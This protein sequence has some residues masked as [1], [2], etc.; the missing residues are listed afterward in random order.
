MR[1][2]HNSLYCSF[3]CAL[4]P[5][6]TLGGGGWGGGTKS[7]IAVTVCSVDID[8]RGCFSQVESGVIRSTSPEH[9]DSVFEDGVR[10]R[11]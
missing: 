1:L 2:A 10:R 6:G 4:Y 9:N 11:G 7:A 5:S 3:H 8:R